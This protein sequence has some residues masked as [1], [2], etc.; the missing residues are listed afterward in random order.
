[1]SLKGAVIMVAWI[2]LVNDSHERLYELS[3]KPPRI[4]AFHR[5]PWPHF[6]PERVPQ[7]SPAAADGSRHGFTNRFAA[8]FSTATSPP[9]LTSASRPSPWP[10]EPATARSSVPC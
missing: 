7:S 5:G 2:L 3:R 1:M 4:F 6:P 8:R 10:K 9:A